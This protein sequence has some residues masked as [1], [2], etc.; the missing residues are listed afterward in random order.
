MRQIFQTAY[1]PEA[2]LRRL[3]ELQ[4]RLRPVPASIDPVAVRAFPH[5]VN[6]L[7]QAIP[8]WARVW[9]TSR[10]GCTSSARQGI[11]LTEEEG[12]GQCP[13]ARAGPGRKRPNR[14]P[15]FAARAAFGAGPTPARR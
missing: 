4:A 6:R 15:R 14:S 7:R 13:L 1:R 10:D 8:R 3:D 9:R 2:L 5:H 12:V 11:G